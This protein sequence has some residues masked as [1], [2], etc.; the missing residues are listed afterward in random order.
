MIPARNLLHDTWA[1]RTRQAVVN[2]AHRADDFLSRRADVRV[3]FEAASPLSLATFAPVLERLQRDPRLTFSFTA[4]DRA[5]DPAR[6]FTTEG[7]ANRFLP[8]AQARWTKF[9]AY[10]NTDFW[11]MTWLHRRAL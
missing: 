2:A 1:R 11:N 9:D 10:V 8:P 7:L 4:A 6:I 5:W 3:L